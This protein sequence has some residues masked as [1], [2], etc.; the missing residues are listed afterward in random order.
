[1]TER[2]ILPGRSS[3]L[4]DERRQWQW[5]SGDGN[6]IS[7]IPATSGIFPFRV[8]YL[9]RFG[10]AQG[11]RL[12]PFRTSTSTSFASP[13][14]SHSSAAASSSIGNHEVMNGQIFFGPS[15]GW[16]RVSLQGSE[17][18]GGAF[19]IVEL[20]AP[21]LQKESQGGEEE[22]QFERM[23][24]RVREAADQ[25]DSSKSGRASGV[26]V[27]PMEPSASE[28]LVRHQ[29]SLGHRSESEAQWVP[30][31]YFIRGGQGTTTD[32]LLPQGARA[33][34]DNNY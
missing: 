13:L 16:L 17:R 7:L 9:V 33:T 19:P 30:L 31:L 32:Q 21:H 20:S 18:D 26:V 14:A 24:L 28:F 29:H 12:Y 1:M 8:D 6:W 10:S 25:H 5:M 11:S 4:A 3:L 22:E 23:Q 27:V 2:F 34:V 15:Y